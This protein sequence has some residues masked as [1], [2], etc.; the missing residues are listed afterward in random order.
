MRRAT[1]RSVLFVVAVV[2]AHLLA[3]AVGPARTDAGGSRGG[4]GEARSLPLGTTVT[5]TGTVTVPS[6]VFASGT[7]DAGFAI[8][9]QTGGIYVSVATDLG[10]RLREHVQVA[11]QLAESSGQLVLV[12]GGPGDLQRRGQ[13]PQ[14][15]PQRLATNAIGAATAGRLVQ[16]TGTI[17]QAV[18]DD[19]PYG[20]R[21]FV[22]DGSGAAQV[23]VYAS[24]GIEVGG[25]R[26]GQRVRVT[27]LSSQY[28]DHYEIDARIGG[29]IQVL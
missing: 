9:D 5:L 25:L 26:P 12:V 7:S 29:D 1:A 28:S 15:V 14:V 10:L 2:V 8:Q 27:G 20:Y 21:L 17:T 11:G 22:D 16:V 24:T 23:Y 18:V 6:G 13:G 19:L 4:I 3:L